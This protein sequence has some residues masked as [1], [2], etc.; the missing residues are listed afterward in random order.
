M[1]EDNEKEYG[2]VLDGAEDNFTD[3]SQIPEDLEGIPEDI[4]REIM[5]KS[6]ANETENAPAPEPEKPADNVT[7]PYARFKEVTDQKNETEKLLA[8]YRERYGDLNSQPQQ[9]FS[10]S[11]QP[12][13]PQFQPSSIDENFTKQIDD[14]IKQ[15]AMQMSG[16]SNE[17]VEG[18]DYLDDD[19]PKI[20]RWNHAKRLSE[21][22]VY[23]EIAN[24]QILQQQQM[25]LEEMLRN[26]TISDY[27]NYVAQQQAADN[28]SAVQKFAENEFFNAQPE[29]DRQVIT[30]SYARI[31][32][33]IASPADLMV[34]R[35]FFSRAKIA[36]ENGQNQQPQ[37]TQQT[38]PK[39]PAP[40]NFP[41][42]NQ[43]NGMTGSGGGVSQAA[44]ADMLQNKK[45]N[46]IP[47]NYQ[48]MLLGL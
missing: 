38:K 4:A 20:S 24:R 7:I 14:A 10:Q 40:N 5:Q 37:R 23:N 6:A 28:F 12:A 27:R 45:W 18:L 17:D 42:T 32:N 2:D 9:N 26:Q 22:L 11:Q 31:S 33:N 3:D 41:R 8:A 13:Q 25:Q 43:I 47:P 30:A 29:L 15:T 1:T 35:D 39:K 46:Q 16:L 48:K 34:I 19:D 21:T 36:Y 44:L